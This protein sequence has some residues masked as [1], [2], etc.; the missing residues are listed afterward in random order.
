MSKSHLD[1]TVEYMTHPIK[2]LTPVFSRSVWRVLAKNVGIRHQLGD[3]PLANQQHT[4]ASAVLFAGIAQTLI[5]N[6]INRAPTKGRT[7]VS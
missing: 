3:P 5:I 6:F 7:R 2:L 1:R 4:L